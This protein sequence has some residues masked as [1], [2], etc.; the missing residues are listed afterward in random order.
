M[1]LYS[2]PLSMYGAKAEIA[3]LEKE[4]LIEVEQVGF[5]L[6]D[7]Y[8]PKH[9]V[10]RQIN[11]KLQVPVLVDGPLELF[12]STQ[13]FEYFEDIKPAPALWPT[14]PKQRA[15]ARLLE[16]KSDEVF[17][18]KVTTLMPRR[19]AEQTKSEISDT[20]STLQHYLRD[21][22]DRLENRP[23]LAGDFS[24]AD[25]AFYVA[26]YFAR[27]LNVHP[28]RELTH[29]ADWRHR[30]SQRDSVIQVMGTMAVFISSQGLMAPPLD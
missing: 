2:G 9:A 29:L 22:D 28:P 15:E 18:V 3:A 20:V 8:E 27:F 23:F 4:M 26:E 5:S 6:A 12:D 24:Y 30:M 1:K 13:I 19:R 7:R 10:V 17:F 16:L 25:I 11:P 14:D 21:M